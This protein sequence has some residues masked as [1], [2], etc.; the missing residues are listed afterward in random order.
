MQRDIDAILLVTSPSSVLSPLSLALVSHGV[1]SRANDA[2]SA[3]GKPNWTWK[4]S[5]L[6]TDK[7]EKEEK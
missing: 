4:C 6:D 3:R 2:V 5:P 7:E 1:G